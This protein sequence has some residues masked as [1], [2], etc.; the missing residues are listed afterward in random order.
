MDSE[1]FQGNQTC[2][3]DFDY[4]CRFENDQ[5]DAEETIYFY[6][7]LLFCPFDDDD[8]SLFLEAF[9]F[10]YHVGRRNYQPRHFHDKELEGG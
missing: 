4:G 6:D 2:R 5:K 9:V 1:C 7:H 10:D 8:Q 3:W